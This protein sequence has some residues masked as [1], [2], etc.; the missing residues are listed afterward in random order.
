MNSFAETVAPKKPAIEV[1]Q[2]MDSGPERQELIDRMTEI[3]RLDAPWIWGFHPKDYT[4]RHAWLTNRKPSKVGHNTL[5]YQRV[6][7]AL[8]EQ[9]RA[10][11][12]RPVLWPLLL[13]ALAFAAAIWPAWRSYRRRETA[14][15][16]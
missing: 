13:L 8:R 3:L 10:E 4:L 12:N 15:A 16:R 2:A 14:T 7:A 11:W 5:K 1:R 9:R 6:D